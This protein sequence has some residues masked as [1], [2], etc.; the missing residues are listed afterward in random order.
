MESLGQISAMDR[1]K[2]GQLTSIGIDLED[3]E[4][5]CLE[6]FEHMLQNM[7]VDG[8][9]SFLGSIMEEVTE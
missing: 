4:R 9:R 6:R 3:L 2:D 7:R 8:S 5:P 1:C